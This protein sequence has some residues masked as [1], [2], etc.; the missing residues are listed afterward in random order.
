MQRII[1]IN[2]SV[3]ENSILDKDYG[4][5]WSVLFRTFN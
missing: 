4:K 5:Q 2:S 3:N 1:I